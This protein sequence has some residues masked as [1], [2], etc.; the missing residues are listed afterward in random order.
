MWYQ[1][2]CVTDVQENVFLLEIHHHNTTHKSVLAC[3]TQAPVMY[4]TFSSIAFSAILS[5]VRTCNTWFCH[6]IF[7]SYAMKHFLIV[8][9]CLFTHLFLLKHGVCPTPVFRA[10]PHGPWWPLQCGSCHDGNLLQWT[11]MG[12]MTWQSHLAGGDRAP[13]TYRTYLLRENANFNKYIL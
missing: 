1:C 11:L 13:H 6:A 3:N 8:A 12:T 7:A 5:L 9:R 10:L 4:H 2:V